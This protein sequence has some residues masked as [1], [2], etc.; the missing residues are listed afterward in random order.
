V[1]LNETAVRGGDAQG[2]RSYST[3]YT[4]GHCTETSELDSMRT[5]AHE[6]GLPM[7]LAATMPPQPV[8]PNPPPFFSVK[9]R[10][11]TTFSPAR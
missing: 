10:R 6:V 3:A 9:H 7:T 8:E 1:A 2:N 4:L 5:E 11:R